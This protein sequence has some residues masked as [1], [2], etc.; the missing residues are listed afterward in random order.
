MNLDNL[1]VFGVMAVEASRFGAKMM[2]FEATLRRWAALALHARDGHVGV[3]RHAFDFSRFVRKDRE[4][5]LAISHTRLRRLLRHAYRTSPYYRDL[6][7]AK[8]IDP[9]RLTLPEDVRVLPFLTKDIIDAERRRLVSSAFSLSDL[10][11]SYTGGTSGPPTLFYRDRRATSMRIGRQLAILGRCGYRPGERRALVWGAHG[12]LPDASSRRTLRERFRRFAGGTET[13]DCT[14]MDQAAMADFCR[15][16]QAFRPRVLYGYP[17]AL[18]ELAVFVLAGKAPAPRVNAVICTAERL[19]EEQRQALR[20][21]FGGAVFN[22]YCSR[23]HGCMGFECDK[24]NG[25]HLDIGSVHVEVLADGERARPGD[26]GDIVATD[27]LNYGMP[28]IRYRIGDRGAL[29]PHPCECGCPL[30]L[31]SRLEGRVS[32]TLY[33]PDGSAVAGLMLIDLFEDRPTVKEVQVVQD[34]LT[35]VTVLLTVTD[36]FAWDDI[37]TP[38]RDLE[39]IL[40]DGVCVRP[41]VVPDIPRNPHSG[42][43]QEVVCRVRPSV[44]AAQTAPG[45]PASTPAA[46]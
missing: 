4:G 35:E 11:T 16:V 6:W 40:G 36:G 8:G 10:D 46:K 32:D 33:R 13:L 44:P 7:Q 29:S 27:L 12:D 21:A 45:V 22:L 15:R 34:T 23:E 2:P 19:T 41:S 14:V 37:Q 5:V 20:R 39:Q 9:E 42:K 28:I 43:L 3:V 38:V 26:A 31:L 30:P 24:H 1:G 17:N 18:S 25:F